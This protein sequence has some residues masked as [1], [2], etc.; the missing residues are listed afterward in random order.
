MDSRA[1]CLLIFFLTCFAHSHCSGDEEGTIRIPLGP[2]MESVAN[3]TVPALHLE[4]DESLRHRDGLW[5]S[6]EDPFHWAFV[7]GE[8]RSIRIDADVDDESFDRAIFTVWNWFNRPVFQR[9]LEAGKTHPILLE[10]E[11]KGVYQFT[12]DGI[13]SD[14]VRKRL[15][16]SL[17]VSEDLNSARDTWRTE[18]FFLGVC[19]MPGRYHWSFRGEPTLPDGLYAHRARELEAEL[20]ARLGFQ[21]VR[22]DESMEMGRR[23]GRA[24]EYQFDFRRMDEAVSAY[25][26]RGLKLA[27][28]LMNA[29]DWGISDRYAGVKENRWRY[30][31]RED[32]Q[33]SFVRS[34][35]K[36]YGNEA[37]FVQVFNEPDQS[38]FWAGT[39]GEF[40]DQYRYTRD[41]I[42]KQLPGVPIV[43]GGYSLVETDKTRFFS[44]ELKGEVDWIAYHSHGELPDLIEDFRLIREMQRE[45]GH[46]N[47]R[48]VNTEMGF[49]GWRLDQELSKGRIVPQK[50][51]YCWASGHGGVLL[52]G[53]RMTLGPRRVTQDFGFLDHFFCPRY[54]YGSVAAMVSALQGASFDS[55]L[56]ETDRDF[57]Y[58]FR[59]GQD[60]VVAGFTLDQRASFDLRSDAA[61]AK[62]TDEMGNRFDVPDPENLRIELDRYPRYWLLDGCSEVE[63]R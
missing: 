49:D 17:A 40:V 43:N 23:P 27:L 20:L 50:T 59:R 7:E 51:L 10:I 30:P 56:I 25:T 18:E 60:R 19:A 54:V 62:R 44:R 45:A 33:R 4:V 39:P 42:G 36:R 3:S 9:V 21:L 55:K 11:G 6:P 14:V 5:L 2:T 12:L 61:E 22:T 16:R 57:V 58:L 24:N 63:V 1:I 15:V 8:K 46:A 32:V 28:Q 31:R 35:L 52:F 29:P 34:L 48:F 53:G 41:E 47:P 38:L 26:S 13:E 37:Y